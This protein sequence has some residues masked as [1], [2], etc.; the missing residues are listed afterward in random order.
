M[1]TE[2]RPTIHSN[3]TTA[4]ELV[5]QYR[6]AGQA[7]HQALELLY[8]MTPHGRDYYSQGADAVT[9]ARH[10]H[11]ERLAKVRDVLQDLLDLAEHVEEQQVRR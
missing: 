1:S 5:E 7:L 6:A 3:G 4:V 9:L 2:V 8:Q 11:E 10:E